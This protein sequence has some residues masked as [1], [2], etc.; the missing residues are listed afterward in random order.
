MLP[1]SSQH[2][3]SCSEPSNDDSEKPLLKSREPEI[4]LSL[5]FQRLAI[6]TFVPS[7]GALILVFLVGFGVDYMELLNYEWTCGVSFCGLT[8]K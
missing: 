5:P 7:I 3:P 4:L 2:S 1:S 6:Y 8:G